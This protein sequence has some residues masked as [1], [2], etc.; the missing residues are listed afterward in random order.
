MK[1]HL[2]AAAISATLVAP[3]MAQQ[4]TVYGV[5][6]MGLMTTSNDVSG[7]STKTSNFGAGQSTSRI[8]FR[9]DED[10]GGGL[11]ALFQIELGLQDLSQQ[12]SNVPANNGN[13]AATA[14]VNANRDSWIGIQSS[15]LG[16]F[17]VGRQ[18]GANF[19]TWLA[20]DPFGSPNTGSYTDGVRPIAT[21]G[22]DTYTVRLDNVVEWQ[23]VM[24][25]GWFARVQAGQTNA[26][27]SNL[28]RKVMGEVIGA[29][30]QYDAGPL[31]I[32]GSWLQ[33]NSGTEER[34]AVAAAAGVVGTSAIAAGTKTERQEYMFGLSYDLGAAKLSVIA[35]DTE[36]TNGVTNVIASGNKHTQIGISVPMGALT[37]GAAMVRGTLEGAAGAKEND[38]DGSMIGATYNLSKRT[39]FYGYVGTGER[40]TVAG[41]RTQ[42]E[43]LS[44]GLRHQF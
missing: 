29:G 23:P 24:P 12:D 41:V 17:T 15:T 13:A 20:L 42:Y 43:A 38:S 5:V 35:Q 1:K 33:I 7:V 34:A 4:V 36:T 44:L 39:N 30:V 27:V 14:T 8:G 40:K 16:R 3:V 21:A 10:L 19:R 18:Y 28:D 22:S 6:D 11:K 9:G 37:L 26:D 32:A 2:L 25:K 31:R